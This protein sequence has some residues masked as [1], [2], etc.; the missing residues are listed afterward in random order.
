[1]GR[2]KKRIKERSEEKRKSSE[3]KEKGD[4]AFS[5]C[6]RKLR[7]DR[8]VKE[9]LTSFGSHKSFTETHL[10]SLFC[11]KIARIS[12]QYSLLAS[13]GIFAWG[14]EGKRP[15]SNYHSSW[16]TL[17]KVL[18][19]LHVFY[20]KMCCFLTVNRD[21]ASKLFLVVLYSKSNFGSFNFWINWFTWQVIWKYI[22]L[23]AYKHIF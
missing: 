19:N 5:V 12:E 9:K 10:L 6:L 2:E 11:S 3:G 1:M 15:N 18:D 13:N 17:F 21:S 7:G 23:D 4:S 22:S 8:I 16:E 20:N 14:G